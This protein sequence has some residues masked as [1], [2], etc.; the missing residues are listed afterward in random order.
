ENTIDDIG[1]SIDDIDKVINQLS[2]SKDEP[3]K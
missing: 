3:K 2:D 1:M